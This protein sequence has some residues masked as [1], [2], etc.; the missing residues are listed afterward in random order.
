MNTALLVLD[1]Q[2]IYTDPKSELYC[3]D[4]KRTLDK[5]NKLVQA[6]RKAGNPIIFVRHVHKVDGSDLGRMFDYAGEVEDFNF[7]EG[8]E[9][10]EFSQ[11]LLRPRESLEIQKTRYSAFADTELDEVL[12]ERNVE[13]VVVCGFMTNFCCN[14]TARDAHDRD[15]FVDFVPDATGTPGVESMDQVKIRRIVGDLLKEGYACVYSTKVYLAS[16]GKV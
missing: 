6:F 13:R 16:I 12:K 4:S 10:V 1:A 15:Y 11:G 2:K 3:K 8:T 14:S 7:K 5:I 9:E